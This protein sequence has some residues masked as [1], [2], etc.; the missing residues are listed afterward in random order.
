MKLSLF[1]WFKGLFK[2]KQ[3]KKV[4]CCSG[5]FDP[6]HKGHIEYLQQAA[7]LGNE[8]IVILNTDKFLLEKKGYVF[9]P[10]EERLFVLENIKCVNKVVVCI[11]E[12]QSV[13][14]TL[15]LI[16]PNI[17]AKGGDRNKGNIP[18]KL[19]CDKL[20]IQIIDGLGE[21]I[22]SSSDLAQKFAETY[23][24][25]KEKKRYKTLVKK[26]VDKGTFF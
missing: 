1:N 4:I 5:G 11:D 24:S 3:E 17:F 18:E 23:N 21:K 13:S 2:P 6:I 7:L 22:S 26:F 8:L 19:V 15:E 16:K 9:M 25:L 10:F 12:D 20:G 14:K